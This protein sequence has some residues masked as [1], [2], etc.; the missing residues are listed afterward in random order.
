[1]NNDAHTNE[2]SSPLSG[3]PCWWAAEVES[4]RQGNRPMGARMR[5][6]LTGHDIGRLLRSRLHVLVIEH[7]PE[8]ELHEYAWATS[9]ETLQEYLDLQHLKRSRLISPR[10]YWTKTGQMFGYSPEE[11]ADF[12]DWQDN[13]EDACECPQCRP[14]SVHRRTPTG[15]YPRWELYY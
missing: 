14:M 11:V 6:K 9:A 12:V 5:G 4:V 2:F 15:Y 10:E 13:A 3:A 8:E 1:M 7:G